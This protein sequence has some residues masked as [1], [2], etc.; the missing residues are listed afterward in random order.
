MVVLKDFDIQDLLGPSP[1][2]GSP[3]VSGVDIQYQCLKWQPH[4]QSTWF[5]L[6]NADLTP[7]YDKVVPLVVNIA[8]YLL[9]VD[10]KLTVM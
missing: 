1:T 8:Y 4:A 9:I 6:L 5:T 10:H 3:R 2:E 7:A